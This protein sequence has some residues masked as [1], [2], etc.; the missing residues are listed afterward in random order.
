MQY[1]VSEEKHNNRKYGGPVGRDKN[2]GPATIKQYQ[3]VCN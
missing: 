2:I 3:I 1:E